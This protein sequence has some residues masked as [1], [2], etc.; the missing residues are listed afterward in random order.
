[1]P[2]TASTWQVTPTISLNEVFDFWNFRQPATNLF[3]ET[4]YAGTS[5]LEPPGAATTTTTPDYQALNQKTK[6]NTFFVAWDVAPR[7]RVSAGYRYRSRIIT[8]A[9]GDVHSSSTKTGP[10]FGLALRPTPQ[11]RINFN[12]DA[13]YADNSFTRISPRQRNTTVCG[14]PTIRIPG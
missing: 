1:M 13:M 9:G 2:T 4:D 14:A 10:L 12:V 7:A 3:T 5:M 6:T 8:D 11:W